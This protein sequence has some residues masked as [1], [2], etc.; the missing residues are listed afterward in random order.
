MGPGV[1]RLERRLADRVIFLIR[2]GVG[3]KTTPSRDRPLPVGVEEVV[4]KDPQRLRLRRPHQL[5]DTPDNVDGR[6][7]LA[8]PWCRRARPPVGWGK[9]R[10]EL[11]AR[12][13][14]APMTSGRV[15]PT[16]L[17]IRVSSTSSFKSQESG[18]CSPV[19]GREVG[20]EY[21]A[22]MQLAPACRSHS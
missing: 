19:R 17:P 1:H 5:H 13:R 15:G 11:P 6:H 9:T 18:R 4:A 2:A 3:R 16:T 22:T 12:S 10:D 21:R 7:G 8:A 14:S 20:A